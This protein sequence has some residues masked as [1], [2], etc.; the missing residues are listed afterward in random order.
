M[1][2]TEHWAQNGMLQVELSVGLLGWQWLLTRVELDGHFR[3][4]L[5]LEQDLQE[6]E[7][8]WHRPEVISLNSPYPHY[9]TQKALSL[10][11]DIK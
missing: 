9:S 2:F 8:G 11:V 7:Q 1:L 5:E 4:L 10:C 3:Q 6:G